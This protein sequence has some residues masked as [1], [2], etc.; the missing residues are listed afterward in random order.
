MKLT[1]LPNEAAHV[2]TSAPLESCEVRQEANFKLCIENY[3]SFLS[4]ELPHGR[5]VGALGRQFDSHDPLR[6][7]SWE[8]V[9]DRQHALPQLIREQVK[10]R[11]HV[12]PQFGFSLG[13]G[14]SLHEENLKNNKGMRTS[15]VVER[16]TLIL[17][18][19]R[20]AIKSSSTRG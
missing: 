17:L 11:S 8:A 18:E 2:G 5:C 10:L 1:R 16:I 4:S 20:W 7:V 13:I 15:N 3:I 14:P 12:G 9:R 19:M 6:V